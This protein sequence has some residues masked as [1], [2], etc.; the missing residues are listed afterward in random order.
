MLR[1]STT[2]CAF[3]V[4][5]F[6]IGDKKT[7]HEENSVKSNRNGTNKRYQITLIAVTLALELSDDH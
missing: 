5:E 1:L 2:A 7:V 6:C 3:S 4:L